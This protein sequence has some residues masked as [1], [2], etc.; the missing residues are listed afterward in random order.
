[1]ARTLFARAPIGVEKVGE[2]CAARL[3]H[4]IHLIRIDVRAQERV[5]ARRLHDELLDEIAVVIRDARF[6][7]AKAPRGTIR[8]ASGRVVASLRRE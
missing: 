7:H 4:R 3:A 5:T 1:M 6:V 8:H 2:A